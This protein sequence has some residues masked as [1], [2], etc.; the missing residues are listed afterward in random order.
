MVR[1][2]TLPLQ[3]QPAPLRFGCARGEGFECGGDASEGF[4]LVCPGELRCALHP[5]LVH[6]RKLAALQVGR[7]RLTPGTPWFSQLAPR[8]LSALE[9]EIC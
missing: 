5:V 8:L 1:F 4:G 3:L 7:C 2:Q 9:T 6:G